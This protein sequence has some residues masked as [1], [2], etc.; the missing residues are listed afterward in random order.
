MNL[1]LSLESKDLLGKQVIYTEIYIQ[2]NA[3]FKRAYALTSIFRSYD[4]KTSKLS[5]FKGVINRK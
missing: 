2:Y 3:I 1:N 5:Y 4:L